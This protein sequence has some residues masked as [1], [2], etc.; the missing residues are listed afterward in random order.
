MF[1]VLIRRFVRLDREDRFLARFREQE[2]SKNPSFKCETLTKVSDDADLPPRLRSLALN[3][4]ACATYLNIARW[5]SREAFL[6]EFQSD[7]DPE[8]E[9]APRQRMLLEIV[10]DTGETAT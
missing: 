10:Q 6:Q 7:F 9:T 8:L 2:P 5:D 4:P 1:I 3:G